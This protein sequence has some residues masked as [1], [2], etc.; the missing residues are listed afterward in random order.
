[1]RRWGGEEF[2]VLALQVPAEQAEQLAERLLCHIGE[3]L[4]MVQGQAVRVTVSIG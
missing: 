1:V 4:V 3:R 2:L